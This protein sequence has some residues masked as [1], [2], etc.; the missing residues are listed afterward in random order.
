[1]TI[2]YRGIVLAIIVVVAMTTCATASAEP[3]GE[4]TL[5]STYTTGDYGTGDSTDIWAMDLQYILGDAWQL[6]IDLPWLVMDTSSGVVH[7][8]AGTM[9]GGGGGGNGD[10]GGG[11]GG[12]G[13]GGGGGDGMVSSD[14]VASGIGDIRVA[15]SR[16]LVGGG[17]RVFRLDAELEV[18]L[19]TADEDKGLGTGEADFRLGFWSGYRFWSSTLY[20]RAGWNRLGDP[21]WGELNDVVDL[22]LGLESDPVVAE[23]LILA[24]WVSARQEVVDDTGEA[25]NI[26]ASLRT[27]GRFRWYGRVLMGLGDASPGISIS[28]GISMGRH[29]PGRIWMGGNPL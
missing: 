29:T 18:K 14:D 6:R 13:N 26:G 2:N 9:P 1:M 24:G 7:T 17:V 19:P 11:G 22:Y 27:T 10:H 3:V 5:F 15:L 20:A 21:W 16:R 23:R 8:G 12:G 4:W 28:I 25:F